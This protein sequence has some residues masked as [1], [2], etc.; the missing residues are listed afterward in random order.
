VPLTSWKFAIMTLWQRAQFMALGR[1]ADRIFFSIDPWAQKYTSWFPDTPVRHLPVGSN[2][3]HLGLSRAE[4]REQ[5]GI[6]EN[7]FV[8]GVF[9]TLGPSRM[10]SFIRQAAS[11]LH[12]QTDDFVVLYVGPD[13][14]SLRDAVE[15]TPLI[16]SGRLSA[17]KVSVHLS[18]MDLHLAP[19][20][21]G[22][23]TRRGSFMAG[24]QH[25]VASLGTIGENTDPIL[26]EA[27]GKAF[28][29]TRVDKPEMYIDQA[30]K[31]L[32][33][34]EHR[35]RIAASGRKLY[36]A[37]FSFEVTAA[38]FHHMIQRHRADMKSRT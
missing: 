29:L 11:A 23:S 30:S 24:V 15:S 5:I 28:S 13:G 37:N 32:N 14:G 35:R 3:P 38:K 33:D 9:G 7:T 19:Y 18:A 8:A 25:G 26:A 36:D 1:A 22:I 10:V 2:I 31:L 21:D 27:N 12:K 4:A 20:I 34:P 16:D 6:D 17:E